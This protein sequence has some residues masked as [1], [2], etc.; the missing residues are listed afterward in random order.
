[1]CP[2]LRDFMRPCP[3]ILSNQVTT[4]TGAPPSTRQYPPLPTVG[5][6][7][8]L[9][10][11]I[12]PTGPTRKSR[13]RGPLISLVKALLRAKSIKIGKTVGKLQVT[14]GKDSGVRYRKGEP[15]LLPLDNRCGLACVGR[16]VAV[17]SHDAYNACDAT[18]AI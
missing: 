14:A 10:P 12:R 11:R 2:G 18:A 4:T 15:T 8:A 13:N 9:E 7:H 5:L 1:M 6:A 17:P 3:C 16:A